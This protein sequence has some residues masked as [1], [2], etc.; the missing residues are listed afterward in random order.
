MLRVAVVFASFL[1]GINSAN[2]VVCD[3]AQTAIADEYLV[4]LQSDGAAVAELTARHAPFGF[5][6]SKGRPANERLLFHGGYI[7]NHDAD[8]RTAL[9]VSYRLTADDIENAEGRERVNCFRS[10]PRLK[11]DHAA[12]EDDY[13]EKT[14]DQGHMTNDAD[15]KDTFIEQL[16]GCRWGELRDLLVD[17]YMHEQKRVLIRKS[18]G[19]RTR[20]VSLSNEAIEFFE[21]T[22]Q[23]RTL[24][25]HM[26]PRDNGTPWEINAQSKA[27]FKVCGV[28]D[29]PQPVRFHTLRHTYATEAILAGVPLSIVAQQLGHCD[30]RMVEKFYSHITPSYVDEVVQKLMPNLLDG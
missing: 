14:Y 23:G 16:T 5:H 7:S 19:G 9:W 24:D 21:V 25:E 4:A 15:L 11:E 27:F 26:F 8:L 29:I 20:T 18:K 13:K 28:A 22:T 30:T 17:D 2:A 10:D 6:H 3:K 1:V 12:N